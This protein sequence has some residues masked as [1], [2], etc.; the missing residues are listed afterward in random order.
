MSY[1][2]NADNQGGERKGLAERFK[3]SLRPDA[4][5]RKVAIAAGAVAAIGAIMTAYGLELGTQPVG[6]QSQ[7]A[8]YDQGYIT[9]IGIDAL[10]GGGLTEA[11]LGVA[12]IRRRRGAELSAPVQSAG[13]LPG[14]APALPPASPEQ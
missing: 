9:D 1:V 14:S 10:V 5:R 13:E 11:A 2:N 6:D 4:L 8:E 3:D 12:A 7:I